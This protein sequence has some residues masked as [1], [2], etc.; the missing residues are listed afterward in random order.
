MSIARGRIVRGPLSSKPPESAAPTGRR[1]P[2]GRL[3]KAAVVDARG[4]AAHILEEARARAEALI[5]RAEEEAAAIRTNAAEEGRAE[6]AAT[7]AAAWLRLRAFDE[8]RAER[9][10][11]KTLALA[12]MIAERLLGEALALDPSHITSIARQALVQ[13]RLARRVL[14]VASPDDATVLAQQKAALGLEHAEIEVQAE[15]SL[16]RGSLRLKTD[17]GNLDA[18]LAPQ[19]DRLVAALRDGLRAG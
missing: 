13:A 10:L 5:T 9:D 8:T 14:I 11:E 4:S 19:L 7:L 17:L 3:T 16:S 15:P 6:G 2:S 1:I 12:R 18:D